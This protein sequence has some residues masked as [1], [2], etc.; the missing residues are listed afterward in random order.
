M[1]T[2]SS[3]LSITDNGDGTSTLV[4]PTEAVPALEACLSLE[5]RNTRIQA[6]FIALRRR[7]KADDAFSLLQQELLREGISLGL[8]SLQKIV[9]PLPPSA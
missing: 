5:L 6:R 9:Y 7:M 1:Q 3:A 2:P 4:V 8:S